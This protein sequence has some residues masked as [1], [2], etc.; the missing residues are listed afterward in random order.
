MLRSPPH[1]QRVGPDPRR[2][3]GAPSAASSG[4]PSSPCLRPS[5]A[6]LVGQA[7]HPP[8]SPARAE[9]TYPGDA[10]LDARLDAATERLAEIA[11]EVEVLADEAKT[12]LAEVTS[13][14]P[15]RLREAS[16]VAAQ[17]ATTIEAESGGAPPRRSADLPGDEPDGDR[18]STAT[19]PSSGGRPSSPRSTRRPSLAAHW[20]QVAARATEAANLT[21]LIARHDQTV[22][23]AAAKG[24]EQSLAARDPIL[25]EALLV[26]AD[27][28]TVRARLIAGSD[29][30]VLDEWIRRN[31][32]YDA[33]PARPVPGAGRAR[34]GGPSRSRSSSRTRDERARFA[35]L[36]PDRRTIIVIVSEVTRGGLTEAVIAIEDAHGRIDDALAEAEPSRARLPRRARR[37]ADGHALLHYTRPTVLRPT[38]HHSRG[39]PCRSSVVADQP[40]DVKADVLAV[41]ILGEPAFSGPLG[42]LDRR[43]GGELQS[44]A[45]FGELKGKRFKT[46]PRRR[47]ARPWPAG[48][49]T[50]LAGD[51]ADARPRDRRQGRARRAERRLAG[52]EVRSLAI[53]VTP[54]AEA[55]EG[56]A[57]AVAELARPRRRRGQLRPG[58]DLPRRATPTARR[59]S[60][61]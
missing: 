20:R 35:Q 46:R 2:S 52:R 4:P 44:L 15:T 27:V 19:R 25:D 11:A 21:T 28:Q 16:S 61:S 22:L 41:P 47:R 49:S 58:D 45:D 13:S 40:W 51:A 17:A 18:S 7:W 29:G 57:A 37:T 5:G 32:D 1:V 34:A 10:A 56:G 43:A 12:A 50:V 48:S 36:P 24:R 6:G 14:D 33:R 42:E 3:S 9:L 54:L 39:F 59:S 38:R 60:T 8:G 31:G 55:L 23:A 53:W 26:V 30:T